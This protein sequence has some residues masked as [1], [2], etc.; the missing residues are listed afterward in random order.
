MQ[1]SFNPNV[2]FT[3]DTHKFREGVSNT[4][5]FF[6]NAGEMT[7]ATAKAVG[8]GTVTA[9][10]TFAGFWLFGALPRSIQNANLAAFKKPLKSLSTKGKVI[11]A[12]A[13]LT[14]A[15]IEL[16]KGKLR[17]NQKTANVDHRLKTGHRAVQ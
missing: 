4:A 3:G 16:I 8:Y 15:G 6:T 12:L 5:K 7:K 17:A 14:V 1:V 11:S 10:A 2:S 9:G 13:G